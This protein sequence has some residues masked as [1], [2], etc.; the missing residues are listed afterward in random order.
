MGSLSPPSASPVTVSGPPPP[1]PPPP[2]GPPP[3]GPG[4]AS[5]NDICT[6]SPELL[7]SCE[8]AFSEPRLADTQSSTAVKMASILTF[9]SIDVTK[10]KAKNT[11]D[12]V[13]KMF[14]KKLLL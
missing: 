13:G 6:P 12:A 1:P 5:Y 7:A 3:S 11:E 8:A 14:M 10:G 2:P 9:P 4:K